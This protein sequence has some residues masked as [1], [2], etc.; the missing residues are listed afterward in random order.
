MNVDGCWRVSVTLDGFLMD[1]GV[2][3]G[4][5]VPKTAAKSAKLRLEPQLPINMHQ[6]PLQTIRDDGKHTKK[7][8]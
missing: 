2:V 1:Y 4:V 5:V 7:H 6:K 3:G 8:I